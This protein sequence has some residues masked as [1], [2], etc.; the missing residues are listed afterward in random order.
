MTSNFAHELRTRSTGPD[1]EADIRENNKW[2]HNTFDAVNWNA[3]GKAV[4]VTSHKRVHLTKFLHDALPTYHHRAN[5]LDSGNRKC[6][7]SGAS[8][9]TTDHIFRCPAASRTEWQSTFWTC[10]ESFHDVYQTHPLLRHLFKE[11]MDQWFEP[12]SPDIASPVLFLAD[13]RPLILTQNK[14]G[15]RQILRGRFSQEWQRIQNAYYMKRRQKS[16]FKRTG[17]RW[18][19]QFISVIWGS[20]FQLWSMRNGEVHGT[21]TETRALAQ[22]K[23]VGRQLTEI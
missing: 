23:E 20:W 19:Q 7:A 21:N 2:D 10:V 4:K 15:W 17:E 14:I 22:R 11:T 9:E 16:A 5:L 6:V 1:L 12:D 13:V 8:D 3:H 18:Q